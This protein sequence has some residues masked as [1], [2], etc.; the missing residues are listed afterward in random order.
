MKITHG[1]IAD[2]NRAWRGAAPRHAIAESGRPLNREGPFARRICLRGTVLLES[3]T[4]TEPSCPKARSRIV[5]IAMAVVAGAAAVLLVAAVG[6]GVSRAVHSP[7]QWT[8]IP[9]E[10]VVRQYLHWSNH[11]VLPSS[12]GAAPAAFPDPL[13]DRCLPRSGTPEIA[14]VSAVFDPFLPEISV[15]TWFFPAMASLYDRLAS[16]IVRTKS[17]DPVFETYFGLAEL[18]QYSPAGQCIDWAGEPPAAM[19]TDAPTRD[20]VEVAKAEVRTL[21]WSSFRHV[22]PDSPLDRMLLA[23]DPLV[24]HV[25]ADS[26]V[27]NLTTDQLRAIFVDR[28]PTWRAAGVAAPGRVFAYERDSDDR[29]QRLAADWL[30]GPGAFL[31]RLNFDA[32]RSKPPPKSLRERFRELREG[33]RYDGDD[34][35]AWAP[36]VSRPG[37]IGFSM[38][39]QAAPFVEDGTI[40]LLS[41]D[42]VAPTAEN[43]ARG[44]YPVGRS[45]EL[46]T[47]GPLPAFT[48]NIGIL[49]DYLRSDPG[50]RLLESA[51]Y[52][53]APPGAPLPPVRDP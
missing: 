14:D 12:P 25:P 6:R 32:P 41:V 52:L 29:A 19:I 8:E 13:P 48:N 46:V 39:V 3:R 30:K 9:S 22:D 5:R 16:G 53:P 2:P 42:G 40:R 44:L 51:G 43:I 23:Y 10:S 4:M 31:E 33:V 17:T 38:H 49:R 20:D 50:R 28:V 35:G 34:P 37:A 18:I 47:F 45:L 7:N 15:D 36:F 21:W 24:F 26:P 1:G 11:H 27:T